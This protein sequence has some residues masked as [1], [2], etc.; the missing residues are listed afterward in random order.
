M[1]T[2]SPSGL[3]T[4]NPSPT[5]A[6]VRCAVLLR[7]LA[8]LGLS[9]W[10]SLLPA[11]DENGQFAIKGMGL[12]TCG[13]FLEARAAQ[14]PEYFQFG[15]W[16]NGYLSATNRYEQQTFDVAPWQSTGLL[17]AWLERFCENDPDVP[18]VRAVT[19]MVNALGKTRLTTQSNRIE[20]RVEDKTVYLYE[21]TLRRVQ[22][23]LVERGHYEGTPTGQF[24]PPTE[25]ALRAFQRA[26]GLQPTGLP[27][28]A[29]LAKLLD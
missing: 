25:A 22:E 7:S 8:I 28:Q 19:M 24:D 9:A 3:H 14:S 12:A 1:T 4:L 17:A 10:S 27:D 20:V 26:T 21:S 15:G 2:A 29:T 11:A 18:F 6:V 13:R 5:N 23:R 16:I